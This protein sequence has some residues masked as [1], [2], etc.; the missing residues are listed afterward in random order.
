MDLS[1]YFQPLKEKFKPGNYESAQ[2]G[3]GIKG[4]L[5]EFPDISSADIALIGVCEDRNAIGNKGCSHAPD[6]VRKHL[7][8][9]FP[10]SFSPN[11]VDFGNILPG[12]TIE[13]T[14]FALSSAITTLIKKNIVPVIIGGGQ[15][16]SYANYTAYQNLEQI[17]NIVSVDNTFD[18]G[19]IDQPIDSRSFL[20]KIILHQPNYLFNYSNLGYQTYLVDPQALD[21]MSKLYFD[22]Y[23]LGFVHA[24][25]EE[26]E[27]I[28][29]NADMLTFDISSI[30]MSD[31]PGNSNAGP[32]GFYGEEACQIVRYAGLS[33]KLSSIGFYELNPE[34]D[35]NGQTAHLT[36]QMI[37]CFIDGFYNRKKDFPVANKSE[38]LKYRVAIQDNKHE[39]VFYKSPKSDRWWMDVPYPP[40]KNQKYERHHLVPCSYADYQTACKEDMPDRW[41]QTFQKLS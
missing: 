19:G 32:N 34:F 33:D 37:W 3:A 35:R 41:W 14:Y 13:D 21:L 7:Y 12:H 15:D 23:R 5:D 1:I 36:A 9:L 24:N 30:R 2:L 26:V 8:K 18:L 4:F 40:G 38:F 11:I 25:I 6:E 16:L 29:R 28:V 31:A 17:V 10:G 39:I 27:P 20:S 22:V